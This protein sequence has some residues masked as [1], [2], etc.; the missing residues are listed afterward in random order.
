MD[1][2][3]LVLIGE[4]VFVAMRAWLTGVA[5]LSDETGDGVVATHPLDSNPPSN[6]KN[7]NIFLHLG[8]IIS[9]LREATSII[10]L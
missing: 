3:A 10:G 1:T 8:W 4:M 2:C 5:E 6:M 9:R 7:D